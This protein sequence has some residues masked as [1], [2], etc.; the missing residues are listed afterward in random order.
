[1]CF[2]FFGTTRRKKKKEKQKKNAVVT[3]LT[4]VRHTQHG[5]A[6]PRLSLDVETHDAWEEEEEEERRASGLNAT[7]PFMYAIAM[8]APRGRGSSG[9]DA[10]AAFVQL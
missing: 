9:D 2:F 1:M 10:G 4:S 8:N 3:G 6:S 7:S 5:T